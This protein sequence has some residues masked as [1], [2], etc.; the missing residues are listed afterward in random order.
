MSR[1][2]RGWAPGALPRPSF[3]EIGRHEGTFVVTDLALDKEQ[4]DRIQAAIEQI[5]GEPVLLVDRDGYFHAIRVVMNARV[6]E[7]HEAF[8]RRGADQKLA[9]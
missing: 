5:T 6:R 2:L 9:G 7:C 1:I 8:D 3:M 4:A